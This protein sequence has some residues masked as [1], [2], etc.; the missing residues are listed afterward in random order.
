MTVDNPSVSTAFLK[1]LVCLVTTSS[2][3][4]REANRETPFFV[5]YFFI[6]SLTLFHP[7][8]TGTGTEVFV[9]GGLET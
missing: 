1:I 3:F 8:G 4:M 9:N 5:F 7:E 2:Y 6:V